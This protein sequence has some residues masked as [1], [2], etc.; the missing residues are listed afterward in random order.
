MAPAELPMHF[1]GHS[2][3]AALLL[4]AAHALAESGIWVEHVTTLDPHPVD[5]IRGPLGADF[6]DGPLVLSDNIR[7]ADNYWRTDGATSLD[8][9]GEEIDGAFNLQLSESSLSSGYLN[10]HSDVHL[11]YHGTINPEHESLDDGS[12]SVSDADSWYAGAMGPRD[13][14]GIPIQPS[15]GRRSDNGG[16]RIWQGASNRM[17]VARSGIQCRILP[18]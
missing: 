6:G 1:I 5:G 18:G 3:G 2:R 4:E 7:F 14:N 16:H 13:G 17:A 11:W 10:E 9:T 15:C 12:A 8:F